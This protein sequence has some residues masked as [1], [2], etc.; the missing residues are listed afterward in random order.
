M[1]KLKIE[2]FKERNLE[3]IEFVSCDW[4]I[5]NTGEKKLLNL[6]KSSFEEDKKLGNVTDSGVKRNTYE[7]AVD[8]SNEEDAL[9]YNITFIDKLL[10]I[11]FSVNC[12]FLSG[13]D[14]DFKILNISAPIEKG[15]I[16]YSIKYPWGTEYLKGDL[17]EQEWTI[18]PCS[19]LSVCAEPLENCEYDVSAFNKLSLKKKRGYLENPYLGYRY[20]IHFKK[21]NVQHTENVIEYFFH[22]CI[23]PRNNLIIFK[24][25]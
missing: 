13:G 15:N 22:E 14:V 7:S 5:S 12:G 10:K 25:L 4:E 6:I 2:D 20:L 23:S 19:V 16:F 3:D 1:K 21:N 11:K 8:G 9:Y 18:H 17:P 24:I